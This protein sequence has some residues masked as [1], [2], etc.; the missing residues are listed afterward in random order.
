MKDSLIKHMRAAYGLSAA[1]EM[2]LPAAL[3]P[4]KLLA[5]HQLDIE[6]V[7]DYPSDVSWLTTELGLEHGDKIRQGAGATAKAVV[8]GSYQSKVFGHAHRKELG[9][10][11]VHTS[12]GPVTILA[13]SPGCACRIDGVVPGRTKQ[14]DWHRGFGI[15]DHAVGR[16][17]SIYDISI[18]GSLAV[19]DKEIFEGRERVEDLRKDIPKWNW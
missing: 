9:G 16:L 12:N 10:R 6:W 7:D 11:T 5:L 2:D 18:D 15:I 8:Q 4:Q 17:F 1:D 13:Y 14:Q 19:W 3:T